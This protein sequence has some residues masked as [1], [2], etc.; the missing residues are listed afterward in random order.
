[1][2]TQSWIALCPAPMIAYLKFSS[3]TGR[4]LQ[5]ILR[6]HGTNL[7]LRRDLLALRHGKPPDSSHHHPDQALLAL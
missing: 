7:F 5:G 1:V 6:L 4:S 3:A 2:L